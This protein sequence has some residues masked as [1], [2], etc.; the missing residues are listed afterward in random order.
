MDIVPGTGVTLRDLQREGHFRYESGHHGDTWLELDRLFVDQARL[1]TIAAELGERLRPHDV[2]AV[3]GPLIG[4]ALLGQWVAHDLRLPFV[5]AERVAPADVESARYRI[6]TAISDVVAGRRVAI[7]D[8]AINAGA[9][10]LATKTDVERLGGRPTVAAA[11]FIREPGGIAL[12]GSNG[13]AVERLLGV[14]FAIWEPSDCPLCHAGL[15][16]EPTG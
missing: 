16:I 7:V 13:L 1:R 5:Y 15:P 11:V 12:L 10:T 14:R 9:A 3:C 4:G 6:P 2:G 8:D